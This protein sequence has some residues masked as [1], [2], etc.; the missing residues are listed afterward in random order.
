MSL[1]TVND[2]EHAEIFLLKHFVYIDSKS[3]E[4]HC[5]DFSIAID[6]TV[7]RPSLTRRK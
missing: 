3:F 4:S 7:N 5:H 1:Q 2:Y 6:G